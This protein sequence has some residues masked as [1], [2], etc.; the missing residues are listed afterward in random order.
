MEYQA[1]AHTIQRIWKMYQDL[2]LYLIK[3]KIKITLAL[4][5]EVKIFQLVHKN[6][7]LF[8]QLILQLE[9]NLV[10]EQE[11]ILNKSFSLQHQITIL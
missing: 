4:T 3:A 2:K 7:T 6:I 1:Q 9:L 10:L 8:I 11:T 5:R